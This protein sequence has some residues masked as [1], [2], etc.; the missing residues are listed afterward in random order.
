MEAKLGV[1]YGLSD[2]WDVMQVDL[3]C[4]GVESYKDYTSGGT[5]CEAI[6]SVELI[7]NIE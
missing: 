5:V 6:I 3:H 4:C 1:S 7:V 2:V